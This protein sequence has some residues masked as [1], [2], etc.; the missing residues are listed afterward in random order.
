MKLGVIGADSSHLPVFSEAIA[1]LNDNGET[2]CKVVAC[3]DPGDHDWPNPDDVA[4]WRSTSESLG[5][6]FVD[7]IDKLLDSVEGVLVL[8]VAGDKHFALS[9]AALERG[10]PTYID[11]PLACTLEEAKEIHQLATS[12]N[13]RCYSASSLR[14]ATELDELP[15]AELGDIVAIDAFGPGELNDGAP[16]VLH[17]GVHTIEMV[18]AIWGPGVKRVSAIATEDRHL[19]DLDYHDGRYARLRLERKGSY[20]FG[21][22]V[23]GTKL[24]HQFKVD[25]APVYERLVQGMVRFFE[26]GDAPSQLEHIVENIAVM[27]AANASIQSSGEWVGI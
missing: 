5:V 15:R 16:G 10:M 4:Q 23:Q 20:D 1:K 7:S 13:A 24:T 18:D 17:Y 27:T 11:K 22:T 14:F 6:S 25:F 9:R 21:A 8:A 2:P 3:H 19:V 12:N 26:G